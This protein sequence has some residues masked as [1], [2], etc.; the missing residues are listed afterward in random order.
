MYIGL[1]PG[2][3]TWTGSD[4]RRLQATKIIY[5]LLKSESET[6]ILGK[7]KKKA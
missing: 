3:G 5:R 4:V 6:R 1:R 2:T 7:K